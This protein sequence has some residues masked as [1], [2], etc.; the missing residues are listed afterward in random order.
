ME[1]ELLTMGEG[2]ELSEQSVLRRR[3]LEGNSRETAGQPA[4]TGAPRRWSVVV[5]TYLPGL[6]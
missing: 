2:A 4:G 3:C 1:C 6:Y 5:N